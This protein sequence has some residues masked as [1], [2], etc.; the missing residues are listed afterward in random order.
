MNELYLLELKLRNCLTILL[1]VVNLNINDEII[2][3]KYVYI[4]DVQSIKNYLYTLGNGLEIK[5]STI[6]DA[7]NGV[8]TRVPIKKDQIIT[9]YYGQIMSNDEIKKMKIETSHTRTLFSQK[10]SIVGTRHE[11]SGLMIDFSNIEEELQGKGVAGFCND[12]IDQSLNN[13]EF[14]RIETNSQYFKSNP[15]L[16]DYIGDDKNIIDSEDLKD[17][18]KGNEISITNKVIIVIRALRDIKE[19]EELLA[20]YGFDYWRREGFPSEQ[21]EP[22]KKKQR[23]RDGIF[24]YNCSSNDIKYID[25]K[26]N[27]YKCKK[28]KTL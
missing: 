5:E 7:G 21:E 6:K 24:C 9:Y 25:Y 10:Y 18:I 16:I 8:F 11:K 23:I 2:K 28:C 13:V 3:Y 27:I 17:L 12:A 19:N 1:K 26:N 15:L 4:N 22:K 14:L 20:D